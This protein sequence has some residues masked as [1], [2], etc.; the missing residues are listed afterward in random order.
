M[1]RR[2]RAKHSAVFARLDSDGDFR[3]VK[4]RRK[5]FLRLHILRAVEFVC[6]AALRDLVDAARGGDFGKPLFEEEVPCVAVRNV[7]KIAFFARAFDICFQN[8]FHGGSPFVIFYQRTGALSTGFGIIFVLL[9]I[10]PL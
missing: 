8:D 5:F 1:R 6:D 9:R 7:D 3:A 2:D 4:F 10:L